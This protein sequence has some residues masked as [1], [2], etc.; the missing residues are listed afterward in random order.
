MTRL[1]TL[2][3]HREQAHHALVLLGVPAPARLVAEVH[4]ALFDGDLSV[5]ALAALLHDEQRR[6][7]PAAPD[8]A[9]F[10]WSPAAGPDAPAAAVPTAQAGG[11]GGTGRRPYL[12]CPGLNLDLTAARGHLTLST[13]ATADRICAPAAARAGALVATV[14]I[15][16]FVAMRPGRCATRLLR[17]LA[18]SVPGGPE[19]GDHPRAVAEAARE[20]LADPA[21][22][23]AV[24]AEAPLRE[25]AARRAARLDEPQRLF[26]VTGLPQQR[27]GA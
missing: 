10:R 26:G 19:V 5:P 12:I 18:A 16:E 2:P 23:D 11:H 7:R 22:A 6:C 20:A 9:A 4:G 24:A 13:W 27:G 8:T 21:L 17:Q 15:A 14:R 1:S 3:S 25:A